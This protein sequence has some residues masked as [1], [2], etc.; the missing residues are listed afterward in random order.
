M[1]IRLKVKR[2]EEQRISKVRD[3]MDMFNVNPNSN[4]NSYQYQ[5]YQPTGAS[6]FSNWTTSTINP[7]IQKTKDLFQIF[8][9]IR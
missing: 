4:S 7:K 1:V 2:Q 6:N 9:L 5:Q 8:G 3:L